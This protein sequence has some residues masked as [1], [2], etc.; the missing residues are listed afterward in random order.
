MFPTVDTLQPA[1]LGAALEER[2][3]ESVWISEH[4]HIP[5][6][7][8]SPFGGRPGAPPLPD[9]YGELY[10]SF[11]TL[12]AIASATS[13]LRL[14]TGIALIAQRDPLWTAKQVATLD[15]LSGGRVIVG[16]GYGWNAEELADHGVAYSD[17]R[18]ALG[19]RVQAMRRLWTDDVAEFHGEFVDFEPSWSWPKPLQRPHPPI[20][21]GA[22]PGPK[23]FAHVIE[24]CDGWMPNYGRYDFDGGVALLH[25]MLAAAGRSPDSIELGLTSVPR[26]PAVIEE[27]AQKG[28]ARLV[29]S[30]RP[31][32]PDELLRDLDACA[33]LITRFA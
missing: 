31:D 29:F 26:D 7:R 4:S 23:T 1:Q 2:G 32:P 13:L 21:L 17:R 18:T 28:V 15:Q 8:R 14:A 24:F 6:S 19:E 11:V 16:V 22:G 33:E 20:V 12:T 3:F 27:L 25:E 9:F 30:L 10:D 5:V